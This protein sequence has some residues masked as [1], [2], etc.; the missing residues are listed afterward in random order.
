[1]ANLTFCLVYG[2]VISLLILE[3]PQTSGLEVCTF[4]RNISL[5]TMEI[6]GIFQCQ[7]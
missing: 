3:D 1:M 2:N 7:N 5:S 6:G 4:G